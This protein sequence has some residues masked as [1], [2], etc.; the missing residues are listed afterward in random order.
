[1]IQSELHFSCED[2]GQIGPITSGGGTAVVCRDAQ[3]R[4]ISAELF[5]F[6]EGRALFGYEQ[7][8]TT[9][10]YRMQ[11][12]M[13]ADRLVM[14]SRKVFIRSEVDRIINEAKFL[15]SYTSLNPVYDVDSIIK[16]NPPCG[17]FQAAVYLSDGRVYFDSTI[18]NLLSENNRAGLI[19][20]EALYSF[21]RQAENAK[22]SGRTRQYVAYT[23]GRNPLYDVEPPLLPGERFEACSTHFSDRNKPNT[24][25]T[26]FHTRLNFDGTWSL[27]FYDFNGKSVL[28]RTEIRGV[29]TGGYSWPI[30]GHATPGGRPGG[31]AESIHSPLSTA[32]DEGW[33]VNSL[34]RDLDSDEHMMILST[35]EDPGSWVYFKCQLFGSY[36]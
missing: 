7:L 5:D 16:P 15:P 31:P 3:G 35:P 8:P 30:S 11:A 20:H 2:L 33:R 13:W 19:A 29:P 10:E 21:F 24:P 6:F 1:M 28:G 34:L 22:T 36:F 25:I 4:P 17:L 26:H 27:Y 32:V 18:W 14:S 12:Q 23:F 9:I